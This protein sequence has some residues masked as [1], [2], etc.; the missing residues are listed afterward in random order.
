MDN[1]GINWEFNFEPLTG[2]E[3]RQTLQRRAITPHEA[4]SPWIAY[5]IAVDTDTAKECQK[6]RKG[7]C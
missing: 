3:G 1:D 5:A 4:V 6:S 2:G 7:I